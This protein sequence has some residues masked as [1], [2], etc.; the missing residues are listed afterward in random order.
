[1]GRAA[2]AAPSNAGMA[3]IPGAL[4]VS[5]IQPLT[6][7]QLKQLNLWAEQKLEP[8]FHSY[9]VTE[10]P[11]DALA[12]AVCYHRLRASGSPASLQNML[13]SAV[14]NQVTASDRNL[15]AKI[16]EYYQERI[17]LWRLAGVEFTEF[18]RKLEIYVQSNGTQIREGQHGM[19][20]RLPEFYEYDS[21]LDSV[22]ENLVPLTAEQSPSMKTGTVTLTPLSALNR[23]I[24]RGK[25][26]DYW[27]CDANNN[28]YRVSVEYSNTLRKVFE[29]YVFDAQQ[30]F[31]ISGLFEP[32]DLGTNRAFFSARKWQ[33]E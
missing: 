5:S 4:P 6:V 32:R 22:F 8:P 19:L 29:R 23:V 11:E 24:K 13:S 25:F 1:M 27:C 2:P 26:T 33:F 9:T 15:A 17:L 10:C 12:L 20:Y 28:A 31:A 14:A 7:S 18:R 30:D 3:A 21:A 16:R